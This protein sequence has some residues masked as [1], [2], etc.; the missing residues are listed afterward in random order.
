[1]KFQSRVDMSHVGGFTCLKRG[2]N[3]GPSLLPCVRWCAIVPACLLVSVS[4]GSTGCGPQLQF[5]SVQSALHWQRSS[6]AAECDSVDEGSH[7][8]GGGVSERIQFACLR[9]RPGLLCAFLAPLQRRG[10]E[11]QCE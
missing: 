1:M 4:G 8:G 6:T 3:D 9:C 5:S 10:G 11:V 2:C 7:G